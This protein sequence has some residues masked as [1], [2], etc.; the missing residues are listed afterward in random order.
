MSTPDPT[1]ATPATELARVLPRFRGASNRAVLDALYGDVPDHAP[2]DDVEHAVTRFALAA[3]LLLERANPGTVREA[4]AELE[5][6]T[7]ERWPA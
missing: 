3:E 4:V 2:L 7:A 1:P 6:L 5:R